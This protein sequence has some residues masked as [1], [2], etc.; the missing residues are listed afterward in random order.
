MLTNTLPS[1]F[2]E[3]L[4]QLLEVSPDTWII[5]E[6]TGKIVSASRQA[7]ELF[8][9]AGKELSGKDF[10]ILLP[11]RYLEEGKKFMKKY[12]LNPFA[13]RMGRAN[14][15]IYAIKKDGTEF[16]A[17]VGFQAVDT[18]EGVWLISSIKDETLQ[19]SLFFTSFMD[20]TPVFTWISDRDENMV[21]ASRS[22]LNYFGFS[23]DPKGKNIYE[24]FPGRMAD[25]IHRNYEKVLGK[26]ILCKSIITLN[27]A[28]GEEK[29][30]QLT[31]LLMRGIAAEKMVGG[32]ARD[33]TE[34]YK[35]R[36]R[37]LKA[38]ERLI[39]IS[40]TVSDAIWDWN[41]QAGTVFRNRALL[42]MIGFQTHKSADLSWWYLR[43]HP[44]DRKR[45]KNKV[46]D[47]LENKEKVWE[48][49]YRFRCA[50]NCY[51]SVHDRGY[52]VYQN[53]QP[54]RMIGSLQDISEIKELEAKLNGEKMKQQEEM[55]EAVI[56][57]QEHERI[58]IGCELHDNVSQVLLSAALYLDAIKPADEE[59]AEIKKKTRSFIL[60]GIEEIRNLSRILVNHQPKEKGLI[61]GINDLVADLV[62]FDLFEI[63]FS[64]EDDCK[65][66]SSGQNKKTTL[67]RIVQELIKNIIKY[68]Q[69]KKVSIRLSVRQGHLSLLVQDDGIGFDILQTR[70]G[71]GLSNIRERCRV[72]CGTAR[73]QTAPGK[74]CSVTIEIPLDPA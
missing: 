44:E 39:N 10:E 53:N 24:L 1:F 45:V 14:R 60:M 27:N 54:I 5:I 25:A 41:M 32:E 52:I 38:N 65:I 21:Y 62:F 7:E 61:P 63:E 51:K 70:E 68:S 29:V 40:R 37:L 72:H 9:Y 22:L 35:L 50:D 18:D 58:N 3:R 43:I 34:T 31:I 57:A 28:N 74:G 2:S 67:F 26:G 36:Q 20:H 64:H 47:V 33:I 6:S 19:K 30:F 48:D 15:S 46:R 73:L 8:G 12:F 42:N 49:E 71:I 59:S 11:D 55:A 66:E 16:N 23:H 56:Q 17:E 13:W 69:A 4:R